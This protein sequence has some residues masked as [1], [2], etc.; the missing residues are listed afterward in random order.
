M[1]ETIRRSTDATGGYMTAEGVRFSG[2][3]A[4]HRIDHEMRVSGY[5]PVGE[6]Q[7]GSRTF[8]PKERTEQ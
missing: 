8:R 1:T 6:W 4:T 7:D 3:A 5:E 2:L